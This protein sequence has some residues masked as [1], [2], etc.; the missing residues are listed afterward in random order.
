MTANRSATAQWIGSGTEGRGRLHTPSQVLTNTPYSYLTRFA[1]GAGTNPE[2]LIAAAHASCFCM[3][4]VFSL[5]AAGLL[6]TSIHVS[7]QLLMENGTIVESYLQVEAVVPGLLPAAFDV[8]ALDAQQN[9]PVSKLLLLPVKLQATLRQE[10]TPTPYASN[11]T[12][13]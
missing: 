12:A 9:C 2:E 3:K 5:Q 4:L 1:E 7:C 6:V 13:G 11:A 8:L 10:S